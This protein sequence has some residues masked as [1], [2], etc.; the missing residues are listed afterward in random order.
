M[1]ILKNRLHVS[2]DKDRELS[3]WCRNLMKL[4]DKNLER[5]PKSMLINCFKF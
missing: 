3:C 4:E 2:L 5:D 1:A